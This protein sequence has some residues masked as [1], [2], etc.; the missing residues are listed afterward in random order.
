MWVLIDKTGHTYSHK[1]GVLTIFRDY[2]RAVMWSYYELKRE[3]EWKVN[4]II[5][6]EDIIVD[7]CANFI[8]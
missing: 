4:E 1:P 5:V 6:D 3:M 2:H 8:D 7:S